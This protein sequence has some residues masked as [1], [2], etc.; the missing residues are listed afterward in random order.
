MPQVQLLKKKIILEERNIYHTSHPHLGFPFY[1]DR[2][3]TLV[4]NEAPNCK[5]LFMKKNKNLKSE[6]CF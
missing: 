2:R 3:D 6:V 1:K 4:S 5:I